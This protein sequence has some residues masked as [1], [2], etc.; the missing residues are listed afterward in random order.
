MVCLV[1]WCNQRGLC[2]SI[3]MV[4]VVCSKN[5]ASKSGY[6][7]AGVLIPYNQGLQCLHTYICCTWAGFKGK[8][9]R[10]SC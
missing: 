2:R 6:L 9:E 5:G 4:S 3:K 8:T 1:F 7:H 10:D